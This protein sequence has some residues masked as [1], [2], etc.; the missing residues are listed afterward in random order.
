MPFLP[1]SVF[2]IHGFRHNVFY[3]YITLGNVF[4]LAAKMLPLLL[5]WLT[6][7]RMKYLLA[8]VEDLEFFKERC[9]FARISKTMQVDDIRCSFDNLSA[10]GCLCRMLCHG[11]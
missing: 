7:K 6:Y 11:L 5:W 10:Y 3:S 9:D 8:L 2:P 1:S 4:V